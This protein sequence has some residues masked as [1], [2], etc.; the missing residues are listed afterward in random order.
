MPRKKTLTGLFSHLFLS[1]ECFTYHIKEERSLPSSSAKMARALIA[2]YALAG[3]ATAT[4]KATIV[5]ACPFVV[6]VSSVQ[7]PTITQ[8]VQELKPGESYAENYKPR[9]CFDAENNTCTGTSI[10]I[11]RSPSLVPLSQFEYTFI[12]ENSD[13]S[14][15]DLFYDMSDIDDGRPRQFCQYGYS[16]KSVCNER[17]CFIPRN[18]CVEVSCLPACDLTC[19]NVY[20]VYND[21]FAT[22]ACRSHVGLSLV[23]CDYFRR[24]HV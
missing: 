7:S 8:T 6:Y 4:A 13:T 2:L 19:P 12:P 23:L 9:I 22:H 17:V 3:T 20:N 1:Q 11:S 24:V 21:D 18:E 15:P 5:N 16:L 10:K 14:M